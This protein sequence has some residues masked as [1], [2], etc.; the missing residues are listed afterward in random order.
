MKRVQLIHWKPAEA[1]ARVEELEAAGYRTT[2][3]PFQGSPTLRRLRAG[4][5]D[6]VVIDLDRVPSQGRDVASL[7]RQ[8]KATRGL[9]LV[10]A[11]GEKEKVAKIEKT[12][13]DAVF[14]PWSRIRSGLQ[15]AIARPPA[16]PVVPASALAGY[17]GTP[18]P[19]KLGIKP[20]TVVTLL[21]APEGF[22]AALEPVPDNVRF[23]RRGQGAANMILLFAKSQAEME[24]RFPTAARCLAVGGGLWI[25]WPKKASGVATDLTQAA[26]RSFGLGSN[27]VDYKI[28]AI[29]ETWSGLLFAR[30]KKAG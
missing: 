28:C 25:A 27:F 3:E 15:R 11:G 20:D 23:R 22:E 8:S 2:Y 21:G 1:E 14:T 18:L 10:F 12:L 16:D 13:P 9:P 5:P 7:L 4:P 29:D 24:R 26:V 6:A 17:S 19:R 30:R